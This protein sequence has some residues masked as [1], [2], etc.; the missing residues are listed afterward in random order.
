[1]ARSLL[2]DRLSADSGGGGGGGAVN[3][4]NIELTAAAGTI[5][6]LH[7]FSA[8]LRECGDDGSPRLA[9]RNSLI[10]SG[11]PLSGV[12]RHR[13]HEA[14][15]GMTPAGAVSLIAANMTVR[16]LLAVPALI[17]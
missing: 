9:V 16:L 8:P 11:R 10:I 15:S 3:A 7:R 14:G 13:I 1:M 2:L 4:C 12:A 17:S 5:A 6:V